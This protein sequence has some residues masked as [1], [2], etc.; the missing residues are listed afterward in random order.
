MR[1]DLV[2]FA[3]LTNSKV[4]ADIVAPHGYHLADAL[5]KLKSLAAYAEKQG[6]HFRRIEAVAK[7]GTGYR[8]LDLTE[9]SARRAV[10]E[11]SSA[12]TLYNSD[13][14]DDYAT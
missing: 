5:S 1:P 9:T 11:A 4:V 13:A 6:A 8:V 10:T 12:E 14:A 2:F 3:R 7:T